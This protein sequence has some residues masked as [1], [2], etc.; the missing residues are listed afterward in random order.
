MPKPHTAQMPCGAKKQTASHKSSRR[1]GR[2]TYQDCRPYDV[3]RNSMQ[4]FA[5]PSQS[6]SDQR[7][8]PK[9][10]GQRE[11]GKEEKASN[12]MECSLCSSI[13][14][15]KFQVLLL[16][17]VVLAHV[18]AFI[19]CA[20]RASFLTIALSPSASQEKGRLR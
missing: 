15:G 11:E 9:S 16:C 19:K 4:P 7:R 18:T 1:V 14:R 6:R 2:S 3:P 8:S 5:S 12:K 10:I 13:P 17:R 20:F